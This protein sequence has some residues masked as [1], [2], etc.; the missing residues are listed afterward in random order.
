MDQSAHISNSW[1]DILVKILYSKMACKDY[2]EATVKQGV[3][4]HITCLTSG[5]L[6][7]MIGHDEIEATRFLLLSVC[8]S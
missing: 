2:I 6:I 5:I 8:S 4:I 3:K 1:D 7:F